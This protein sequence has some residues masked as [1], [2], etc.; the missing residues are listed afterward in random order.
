MTVT[1]EQA[2]ADRIASGHQPIA[3]MLDLVD[4]IGSGGWPIGGRRKAGF[5]IADRSATSRHSGRWWGL[6]VGLC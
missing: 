1:G 4:P 2:N 3:V 5:D 6:R